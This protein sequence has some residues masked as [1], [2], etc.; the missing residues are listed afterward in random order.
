MVK[1]GKTLTLEIIKP[2]KKIALIEKSKSINAVATSTSISLVFHKT[3][4]AAEKKAWIS[5][6]P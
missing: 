4:V 6:K 3:I 2:R 1:A 5:S